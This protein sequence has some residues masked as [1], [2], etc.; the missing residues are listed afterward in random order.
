MLLGY[1]FIVLLF[2]NKDISLW[3]AQVHAVS[4]DNMTEDSFFARTLSARL[5]T[6]I[7]QLVVII[8][9][10]ISSSKWHNKLYRS[11]PQKI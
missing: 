7:E 5:V 10:S 1:M 4:K 6:K 3:L 11:D 8:I 2:D 9:T